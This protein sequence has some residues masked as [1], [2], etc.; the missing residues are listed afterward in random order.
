MQGRMT[1]VCRPPVRLAAW[2]REMHIPAAAASAAATCLA[3]WLYGARPAGGI[4]CRATKRLVTL[5][6]MSSGTASLAFTTMRLTAPFTTEDDQTYT[7]TTNS[8]V[9]L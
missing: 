7:D 9:L 1:S 6:G 4:R 3:P 8:T 2:G 5:I